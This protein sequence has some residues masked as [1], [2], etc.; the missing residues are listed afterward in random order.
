MF[1]LEAIKSTR[2]L[3]CLGFINGKVDCLFYW[4]CCAS[5]WLCFGFFGAF[6]STKQTLCSCKYSDRFVLLYHGFYICP[7]INPCMY[8]YSSLYLINPPNKQYLLIPHK[9]RQEGRCCHAPLLLSIFALFLYCCY[10]SIFWKESP[11]Y[12]KNYSP[13]SAISTLIS[14]SLMP[15]IASPRSSDTS[16]ITL[17]SL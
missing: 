15:T 5:F 17:A 14:L 16:A 4:L 6:S 2:F 9:Q 3:C 1:S 7:I 8:Q 10:K 13:R 12:T 11:A